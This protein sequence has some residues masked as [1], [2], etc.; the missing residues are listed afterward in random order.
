MTWYVKTGRIRVSIHPKLI[1]A[2]RK[3]VVNNLELWLGAIGAP[4]VNLIHPRSP[5]HMNAAVRRMAGAASTLQLQLT[6][7]KFGIFCLRV[8][9]FQSEVLP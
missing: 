4:S 7:V 9:S 3:L 6:Q 2:A 8:R 1:T 5:N